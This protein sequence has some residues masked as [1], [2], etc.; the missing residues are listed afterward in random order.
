MQLQNGYLANYKQRI[1]IT[2]NFVGLRGS[3]DVDLGALQKSTYGLPLWGARK[4]GSSGQISDDRGCLS[5][6]FLVDWQTTHAQSMSVTEVFV[7]RNFE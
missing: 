4:S 2:G 3:K 5:Q 7:P 1:R 6:K